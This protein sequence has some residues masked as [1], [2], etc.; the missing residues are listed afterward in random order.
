MRGEC[1]VGGIKVT[2]YVTQAA[3]FCAITG[4][5]YT[6]TDKSGSDQEEGT[7]T[8]PSTATPIWGSE[9][10]DTARACIFRQPVIGYRIGRQTEPSNEGILSS[11]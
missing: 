4:G 5:E 1:P 10:L 6:V 8:L 7:C 2:G 11:R 9:T 3:R